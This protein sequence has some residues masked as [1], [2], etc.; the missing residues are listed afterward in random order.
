MF[1]STIYTGRSI[2]RTR[3]RQTRPAVMLTS[4][5]TWIP[6]P[7]LLLHNCGF[8]SVGYMLYIYI[9]MYNVYIYIYI[10]IHMRVCV[11]VYIYIY[12]SRERERER[13]RQR[14]R[15]I[16]QARRALPG[17]WALCPSPRRGARPICMYM[18]IYVCIYIYIYMRIYVHIYICIYIYIYTCVY[19]Y[20][21][22]YIDR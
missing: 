11:C 13:P 17:R 9:Y 8:E 12:I 18:Y 19:I 14:Q 7:I 5:N 22:V 16:G 3:P 2:A 6:K 1:A 21:Y 4:G 20:I 15:Y 10:Y